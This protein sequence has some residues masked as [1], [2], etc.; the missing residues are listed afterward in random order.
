LF[1]PTEAQTYDTSELTS[2]EGE[3]M[4]ATTFDRAPRASL[5]ALLGLCAIALLVPLASSAGAAPA[6]RSA[7]IKIGEVFYQYD[8]Y[9]LALEKWMKK[10]AKAKGID[11]VSCNGKAQ[12]QVGIDC[13]NDWVAQ[14]VD[15]IA[16]HPADPAAAVGPVK[17]AQAAGIPIIGVAIR[18]NSPAKLPFADINERAQTFAAGV[19]AAKSAKKLF[20]GKTPSV[21]ALDL[22]QLPICKTLR[23]GGFIAG[24]KSVDPKAKIYDVGVKGDRL[25]STNVTADFVQSGREFNIITGCTGEIIQGA[26]SALKSAGRGKAVNKKPVSE[27]VFAIDG[28]SVQLGQLLDKSSPVMQSMGLT[29]KDNA[30]KILGLLLQMVDKKV[31]ITST[32]TVKLTSFLVKP[33]CKA[34][35]AYLTSQYL[36]KPLSC[37]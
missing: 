33:D 20:P 14:K 9:Q 21:L 13:I 31:P 12:A 24:V 23:M 2:D 30:V 11:F 7:T 16:Y 18:P 5:R 26:L 22:V 34:V 15:A 6:H 29:P 28:D 3:A 10:D 32:T 35:N 8:P 19:A 25:D 36:A 27:Y 1:P 4:K 37:T 17:A